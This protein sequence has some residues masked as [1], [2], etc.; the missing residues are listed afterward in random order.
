MTPAARQ[1]ILTA[2]R[3]AGRPLRDVVGPPRRGIGQLATA[4]LIIDKAARDRLAIFDPATAPLLR[5][6]VRGVDIQPWRYLTPR[7]LIALPDGWTARTFGEAIEPAEAW[8]LLGERYPQIRQR[9]ALRR[10]AG[11]RAWWELPRELAS[12]DQ[13]QLVWPAASMRPRFALTMPGHL[14][15]PGAC[16]VPG[17]PF[18]LG[19]LMSRPAWL[20]LSSFYPLGQTHRL[21]PAQVGRLP[22]PEAAPADQEAVGQL[23]QHLMTTSAT[24]AELERGFTQRVLKDFGPPG[25]TPGAPLQNW[26][27][28]DFAGLRDAI[29]RRFGGDIPPRYRE[30][31]QAYHAEAIQ[32]HT[33]LGDTLGLA[34]TALNTRV[35]R[36]YGIDSA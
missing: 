16:H 25:A 18:L 20:A 12:F 1:Q 35:M 4:T 15:G 36:L 34:E 6:I 5:R 19:I 11:Q 26:W 30:P 29:A 27:T 28:L 22:L 17:S 9:L 2:M 8:N 21:W 3:A 7:Y 13:A 10:G 31:W 33:A 14:V 23:A 24:R 32:H